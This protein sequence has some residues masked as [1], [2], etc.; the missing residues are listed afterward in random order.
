MEAGFGL[1]K[2]QPNVRDGQTSDLLD[3]EIARPAL[4]LS[5]SLSR[6]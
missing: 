3:D 4:S 1:G 2:T 6:R 5:I